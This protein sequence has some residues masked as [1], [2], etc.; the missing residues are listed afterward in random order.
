[1]TMRENIRYIDLTPRPSGPR[2]NWAV[3]GAWVGGLAVSLLMW[4][5]FLYYLFARL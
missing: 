2:I 5:V 3:L 1:M 4:G